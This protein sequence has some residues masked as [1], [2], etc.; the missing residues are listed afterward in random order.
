MLLK[1][2]V[3]GNLENCSCHIIKSI[4]QWQVKKQRNYKVTFM[5]HLNVPKNNV[6]LMP[7]CCNKSVDNVVVT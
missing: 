1:I 2:R 4:S 6:I 7:F 5:H 3:L